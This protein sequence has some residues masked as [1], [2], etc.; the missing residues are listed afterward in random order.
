MVWKRTQEQ[1]R[2]ALMGGRLLLI[3][4]N[5]ESKDGVIH[6]VAGAIH[7]YTHELKSLSVSSR[8]FR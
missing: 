3:K 6:V 1:F 8:D 2:Q 4:G 7:D 5:V